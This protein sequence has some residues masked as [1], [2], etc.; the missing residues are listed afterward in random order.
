MQITYTFNGY[1]PQKTLDVPSFEKGKNHWPRELKGSVLVCM[2]K[3]CN[4]PNFG[5]RRKNSLNTFLADIGKSIL[6]GVKNDCKVSVEKLLFIRFIE[7]TIA[8]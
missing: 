6:R 2:G 4:N 7:T 1:V 3:K 5:I 8:P